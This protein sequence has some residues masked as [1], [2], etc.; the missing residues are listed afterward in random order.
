MSKVS[1]SK[2][3]VPVD[4]TETIAPE[5]SNENAV[6]CDEQ[7]NPV[8][9][10][11]AAPQSAFPFNED[12]I[13]FADI[14]FPKIKVVQ[15]SSTLAV[16]FGQGEIVL[17]D[18]ISIYTPP[19]IKDGQLVKQGSAPLTLV[20]IG[21]RKDR[22][23]EQVPYG[24]DEQGILAHSLQEVARA[25]GTLNYKENK[26]KLAAGMKS[27]LF[28]TLAT[29]LFLVRK[30]DDVKDE[31]G[32]FFP[33]TCEDQ[34]WALVTLDMKG[35]L[36]TEG[37]SIIRNDKKSGHLVSGGY[38]SFTYTCGTKLKTYGTGNTS[39]VTVLKPGTKTSETL[40]AFIK[41]ITGS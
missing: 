24:S 18:Q 40:R 2:P 7:G 15:K 41:Q 6:P 34:K 22:Y 35:G 5:Q 20:V 10:A 30:P 21:F 38:T 25:N 4:A 3:G 19:V 27:R 11:V 12:N 28:Q 33:F 8:C 39:Q 26:E 32:I 23:V 17:K 1:F 13:G 37:A 36:F 14:K 31:D 16:T 29:A 9:S